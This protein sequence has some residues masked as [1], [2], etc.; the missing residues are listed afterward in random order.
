MSPGIF[1]QC[2]SVASPTPTIPCYFSGATSLR[3]GACVRNAR[4]NPSRRGLF[5][6]PATSKGDGDDG[7]RYDP[8]T[9]GTVN[10]SHLLTEATARQLKGDI[11]AAISLTQRALSVMKSNNN[12]GCQ[13]HIV[14]EI[15]DTLSFLGKLYRLQDSME[16][17]ALCF[18]E[19]L[20]LYRE[21]Q[22]QG[23]QKISP[24]Q[25]IASTHTSPADYPQNQLKRK[26]LTALSHLASAQGR[27][28]GTKAYDSA[29]ANFRTA[30]D[31][32]AA[33]VGWEDG[34]TNHTAHE[35]SQFYRRS[36]DP[37]LALSI[38]TSAKDNLAQ[39]F[40][41]EDARVLQLNGEMAELWRALRAE[42]SSGDDPGAGKRRE[43]HD[44]GTDDS[45]QAT[46]LLEEA[47][48][49]LPPNSPEAI[50][51]LMQLEDWKETREQQQ[52][53][54]TGSNSSSGS[55]DSVHRGIVVTR[56][57]GKRRR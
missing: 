32:L 46:A 45:D 22:Q 42:T 28:P 13:G 10:Y 21:Q 3:V 48:D 49:K 43:G 56:T 54:D 34:M 2:V 12:Q 57:E 16:L 6:T 50:R 47:L 1:R 5:A 40:G 29:V 11:T 30:L 37:R 44:T 41:R 25:T 51:I 15:A 23:D 33:T 52:R 9:G 35:W 38:L 4:K 17:A 26:E 31:G 53:G 24:V 20:A 19:A 18:S 14:E 39:V 55:G 27:L 7:P 8:V 36:G